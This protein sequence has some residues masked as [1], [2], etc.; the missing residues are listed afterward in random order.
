MKFI[1]SLAI[2]FA[3]PACADD[4]I[5]SIIPPYPADL[6]ETSG[7]C[8]AGSLGSERI[9]DFSI[10]VLADSKGK[11]RFVYGASHTGRNEKGNALW[12]VTDAFPYPS[13]P[14]GQIISIA[15]C[16]DNGKSDETIVAA[17]SAV[18]AE[19]YEKVF[20]ARRYDFESGKFVSHP[21]KNVRCLNEGWGL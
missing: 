15:T 9:C 10:G 1:A 5:G 2:L 11:H 3:T 18:D 7:A 4:L 6:K 12:R 16:T 20:W 21:P 8:I 14:I 13:L 17:V 19:W